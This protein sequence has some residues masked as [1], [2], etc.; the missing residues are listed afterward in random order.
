MTATDDAVWGRV[1]TLMPEHDCGEQM[2]PG[3]T[4]AT[5]FL[6]V[7]TRCSCIA[8]ADPDWVAAVVDEARR[9]VVLAA[10]T[11]DSDHE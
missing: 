11:E 6:L 5:G 2:R 8:A 1:L 4:P 9:L 7:C 3:G 10:P